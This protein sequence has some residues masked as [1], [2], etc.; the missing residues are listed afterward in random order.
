VTDLLEEIWNTPDRKVVTKV[1]YTDDAHKDTKI[2]QASHKK[3][4]AHAKTLL[5]VLQVIN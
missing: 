4:K 1:I 2:L 3:I 5:A